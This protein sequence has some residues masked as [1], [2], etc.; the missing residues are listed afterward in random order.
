MFRHLVFIRDGCFGIGETLSF[1]LM[2]S[3]NKRVVGRT[4]GCRYL[5]SA[6]KLCTVECLNLKVAVRNSS[7]SVSPRGRTMGAA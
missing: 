7:L 5:E 6:D 3:V 4:M 1:D 2:T